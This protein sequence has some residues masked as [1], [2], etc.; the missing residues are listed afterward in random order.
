MQQARLWLPLSV[1]PSPKPRF[2][3]PRRQQV[4]V[5][6]QPQDP[7]SFAVPNQKRTCLF[8]RTPSNQQAQAACLPL[9]R[10]QV[11]AFLQPQ[12]PLF[13]DAHNQAVAVYEHDWV[14]ERLT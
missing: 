3:L 1:A 4:A 10:Q 2:V 6:L 9:C 13:F 8:Q 7:L 11:A 5:F 14:M 12:D